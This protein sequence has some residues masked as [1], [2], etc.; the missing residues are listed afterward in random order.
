[1][2]TSSSRYRYHNSSESEI[3]ASKAGKDKDFSWIQFG[4]SRLTLKEE[5]FENITGIGRGKYGSVFLARHINSSK[6]VAIKYISKQTV[7]THRCVRKLQQE[8]NVLQT[9]EHP[10]AV[11]CLGGFVTPGCFA[12][13]LEYAFGGELYHRMKNVIKMS[14]DEAKFYFVEIASV[15]AYLHEDLSVVFRDLKPENIL[16]DHEGHIKLCDFGFAVEHKNDSGDPAEDLR[17][18]CGTVM[19]MAPE[20]ASGKLTHGFPCDWWSLGVVLMEMVTGEAP[21][22]D[23]DNMTKFEIFTNISE[24]T[25]IYPI[26]MNFGLRSLLKGLL[27]RDPK[28][29]FNWSEVKTSSWLHNVS[30][31]DVN[32]RKIRPPWIPS[33]AGPGSTENF[34]KWQLTIPKTV[35]EISAETYSQGIVLPKIKEEPRVDPLSLPSLDPMRANLSRRKSSTSNLTSQPSMQKMMSRKNSMMNGA[36]ASEDNNK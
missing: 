18:G 27:N 34:V 2:G 17:D 7:Y 26:F 13:V 30:W 23:S 6:Y 12:L 4:R 33:S 19:Y 9:I 8:I 32:Q 20:I 22:G 3:A 21:F 35:D 5:G 11:K 10:F 36:A 29:R 16:I 24:K 28:Q 1:M 25:I 15:L 31:G 14:D